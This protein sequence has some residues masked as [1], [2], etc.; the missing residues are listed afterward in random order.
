MKILLLI[1]VLLSLNCFN[2]RAQV[3]DNLPWCPSGAMWVYLLNTHWS[4]EYY[5]YEYEKDTL[6]DSE[7]SKVIHFK[8]VELL[9]PSPFIPDPGDYSTFQ[10]IYPKLYLK[11]SN[12]SI[13]SYF[14]NEFKYIYKFNAEIGDTIISNLSGNHPIPFDDYPHFLV[15]DTT[16]IYEVATKTYSNRIFEYYENY[17][18]GRWD[19]G[20]IINKIGGELC[21]LPL[22]THFND[23]ELMFGSHNGKLIFYKDDLRGDINIDLNELGNI[24]D[25][26]PIVDFIL[27]T[28]NIFNNVDAIKMFP[29]P[30][31]QIAYIS[32][33]D[34]VNSY[35]IYDVAGKVW[36]IENTPSSE[37][38]VNDLPAGMYF[39]QFQ[40]ENKNYTLKFIKKQL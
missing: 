22:P 30:V 23:Y 31:D 28:T 17:N 36:K 4:R 8:R 2:T 3:V 20:H 12:D 19:V 18:F 21:L 15:D 39:I 7:L 25:S 27:N 35:T 16:V 26:I 32:N 9:I 10:W 5:I 1:T 14:Q 11:E 24:N 29:N 37:I 13:F 34:N 38:D 33:I 40:N 6:I